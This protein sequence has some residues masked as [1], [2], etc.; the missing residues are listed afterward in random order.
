MIVSRT[1][2]ITALRERMGGR[3]TDADARRFRD[4][5]VESGYAGLDTEMIDDEAW[6]DMLDILDSEAGP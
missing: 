6:H 1:M 4:I 5:L 2:N 3:A